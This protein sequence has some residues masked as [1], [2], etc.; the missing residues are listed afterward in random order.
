MTTTK[1]LF[2]EHIGKMAK[3]GA[4]AMEFDLNTVLGTGKE[5]C[6]IWSL[7]ILANEVLNNSSQSWHSSRKT[8][9]FCLLSQIY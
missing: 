4:N 6:S 5:D 7:Y 3:I 1:Q 8:I 2:K 9:H